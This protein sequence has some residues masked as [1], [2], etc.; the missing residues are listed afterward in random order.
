[1][2]GAS[3]HLY[4]H[5]HTN[6]HV[7]TSLQQVYVGAPHW[8]KALRPKVCRHDCIGILLAVPF[9]VFVETVD[10]FLTDFSLRARLAV[11]YCIHRAHHGGGDYNRS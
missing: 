5:T 7:G 10:Q 8:C 1:M 11:G 2:P 9:R 3:T 6:L 4:T